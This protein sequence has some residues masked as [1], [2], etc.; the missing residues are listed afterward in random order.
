MLH[1]Y[2]IIAWRN[3]LRHK[4]FSLIN[5]SGLAIG[6]AA[7]LLILQ[8]VSFELSYDRFHAKA[9]RIFRV[10]LLGE[11]GEGSEQDACVYNAAGPAMQADFPEV[12]DYTH[13]RLRD[14]CVFSLGN[15]RLRESKV[16]V[17]SDHF[18]TLFSFPLLQGNPVTALQR[19]NTV[20]LSQITARKYFGK[21]DPMG[22][23][24]RFDDGY[25]QGLLTVTGVMQAMPANSHLH[26]DILISY[27]TAKD[28]DSWTFNWNGNN[29]YLYVL[30]DKETHSQK[31]ASQLT[32]FTRKYLKQSD[33]TLEIQ[34]LRDIHLHSHKT[35]EAEPNGSA[36]AVYLLLTVG[37]LILIIAWVNY[38]NLATARSVERAKEV[39]IRKV[40]GSSRGQLIKQ[41]LLESILINLL[42]VILAITWVQLS[43]P[44]LDKMTGQPLSTFPT[45]QIYWWA[46]LAIFGLGAM[47]AGFYPAL[48]ISGFQPI[49]VLKG[50][51][52]SS[53]RGIFLRKSLVIVQFAATI[54]VIVGTVTVDWQLRYM[55]QQHLGMN[56]DQRLVLYAPRSSALD[57]LRSDKFERFKQK[58]HQ[59][60]SVQS[61]SVSECLPGNGMYELNSNSGDIRRPGDTGSEQ[62]RFFL[63]GIDA[64]FVRTLDM[65]LLI[66]EGFS[67]EHRSENRGKILANEAAIRLLGYGSPKQAI[68]QSINWAGE[69]RE[70]VGIIGN[71]H[72]HSLERAFDPMVY[73]CDETYENA[74][75]LTI[76]LNPDIAHSGNL[77]ETVIHIKAIW[78]KTFP[79]S[80]FDYFFLDERFNSQYKADQ[81]FGQVFGLFAVLAIFV[82]CLGL[83][84]LALFTTTQR[85]KE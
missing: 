84:G 28:W 59:L 46:W 80:P 52:A 54:T 20:V 42:A 33:Q 5:I 56:I 19:P 47:A 75:Y 29:D 44:L 38:V 21:A 82:A 8:Y 68:H 72:H 64:D 65:Q 63:F 30:L 1:N 76:K 13:V 48:I 83:F 69:K 85:T 2:L 43:L 4:V 10:S 37:V 51:M 79:S 22:K 71:Y 14:N 70:I 25:H 78:G 77:Q 12:V 55:Q 62:K 58:A 3:L 15:I 23:T 17:A 26:L 49:M 45:D 74:S 41:F 40:V 60:A 7:C 31:V 50:R 32:A 53:R 16:G 35:Y 27:S 34:A 66:G 36:Q 81:Q 73:Y 18:L 67:N 39:G 6:M 11:T 9:D 57:S 61:V 24:I